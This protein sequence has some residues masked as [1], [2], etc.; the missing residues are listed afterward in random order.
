MDGNPAVASLCAIACK[1]SGSRAPGA[2]GALQLFADAL[3]NVA[4]LPV[5]DVLFGTNFVADVTLGIGEVVHDYL[6]Q[7]HEALGRASR[8]AT[9]A[10][11]SKMTLEL[12][13]VRGCQ[14]AGSMG[15]K[16]LNFIK[17]NILSKLFRGSVRGYRAQVGVMH[18]RAI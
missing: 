7:D 4:K 11:R 2:A 5:L 10:P 1:A 9:D 13:R 3:S 15:S 8:R 16:I 17:F 14:V 12:V 18:N 6:A